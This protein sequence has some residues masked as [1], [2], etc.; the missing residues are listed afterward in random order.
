MGRAAAA[1]A[2][3]LGAAGT[4]TAYATARRAVSH[5]GAPGLEPKTWNRVNY[6][7]E[8]VTLLEGPAFVTGAGLAVA[9]APGLPGS[10]RAAAVGATVGAGALGVYDD[11]RG[12]ADR[13]GLRGHLA[14]L[15]HGEVT[16]GAV[17]FLGIGAIGLLAGSAVRRGTQ[18]SAVDRLLAG[19]VI[20]GAA[21]AVNLLDLRPGRAVKAA[22]I[23]AAPGVLRPAPGAAASVVLRAAALG[24]AAAA[25]PDD[26]AERSMLGDAGANAL[27]ALLGTAAAASASRSGLAWRAAV[28]TAATVASEK[29]SFTRVIAN[30]PPLRALDGIGRR[31]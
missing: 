9:L 16:T 23:A 27:G 3:A 19:I 29:V 6:R 2:A 15:R 21:N 8:P 11:L 26:L 31:A 30:C 18:D 13:R 28:L 25:L 14:A 1:F 10:L 20:A 17:K 4:A 22:V 7:G 5:G 24:A 12:T